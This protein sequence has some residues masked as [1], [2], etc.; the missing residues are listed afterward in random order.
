MTSMQK[1]NGAG[2]A[3]WFEDVNMHLH[4]TIPIQEVLSMLPSL[5]DATDGKA[6][7]QPSRTH[8]CSSK[9]QSA[10]R[11]SQGALDVHD[12]TSDS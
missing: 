3:R 11:E 10:V 1:P 2:T 7:D 4:K 9:A 6:L 12:L 5:A 8:V